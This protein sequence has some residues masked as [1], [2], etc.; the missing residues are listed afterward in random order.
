MDDYQAQLNERSQKMAENEVLRPRNHA[1]LADTDGFI[2]G[3]A[4]IKVPYCDPFGAQSMARPE[5]ELERLCAMLD[6]A[7]KNL[8]SGLEAIRGHLDRITGNQ[9]TQTYAA[10]TDCPSE[11][12]TSFQNAHLRAERIARDTEILCEHIDRLDNI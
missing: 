10:D 1:G 2:A 8:A 11:P 9:V 6:R 12:R 7:E 3:G 5:R 4:K